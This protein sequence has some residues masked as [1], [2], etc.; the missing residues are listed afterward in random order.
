MNNTK[1]EYIDKLYDATLV[2]GSDSWKDGP[3]P[4]EVAGAINMLQEAIERYCPK[5]PK[6]P[7]CYTQH[8]VET[9]CS[10]IRI[11]CEGIAYN[12]YAQKL[13]QYNKGL[14]NEG[15]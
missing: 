4:D 1:G 2:T 11:Q 14:Q 8:H 12:Y 3:L 5:P 9:P 7:L 6:C 10:E 13:A 15:G